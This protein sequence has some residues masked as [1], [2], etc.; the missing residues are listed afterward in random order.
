MGERA[1]RRDGAN[2]ACRG[3]SQ[4]SG[5]FQGEIVVRNTGGSTINGWALRW[6]FPDSRRVTNLWGGTATQSSAEVSVASAAYTAQIPAT[7]SVTLGFAA[8][9]DT[10]NPS[11]SAFTLNGATCSLA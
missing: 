3:T 11:P 10:A 6:T 1:G 7:G 9:R 8:T 4:W 2:V 5:G